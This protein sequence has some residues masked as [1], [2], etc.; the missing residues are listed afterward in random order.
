MCGDG[1]RD[2]EDNDGEHPRQEPCGESVENE[3][4]PCEIHDRVN[5]DTPPEHGGVFHSLIMRYITLP[6]L[7]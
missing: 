1:R 2:D 5:H 7:L 3:S 6:A 4:R